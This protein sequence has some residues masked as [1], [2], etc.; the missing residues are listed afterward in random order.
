MD[1]VCILIA[2]EAPAWPTNLLHVATAVK[3]RD[4][5]VPQRRWVL[6]SDRVK[7]KFILLE[8]GV[9]C[10]DAWAVTVC[11]KSLR[12]SGGRSCS[13]R[14]YGAWVWRRRV[15]LPHLD[16]HRSIHVSEGRQSPRQT[17]LESVPMLPPAEARLSGRR[18]N[19]RQEMNLL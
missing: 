10:Q 17:W 5:F 9:W 19:L 3:G 15:N 6:Q 2:D 11:D 12:R 13:C 18:K 1:S 14:H 7:Q 8:A 16:L 4:P